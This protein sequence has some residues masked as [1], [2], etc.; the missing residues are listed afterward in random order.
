MTPALEPT[1]SLQESTRV[2]TLWRFRS[3]QELGY[4]Y[5]ALSQHTTRAFKY[6]MVDPF[7][8]YTTEMLDLLKTTLCFWASKTNLLGENL[9]KLHK[10]SRILVANMIDLFLTKR[11]L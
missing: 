5:Y 4:V 2:A 8:F 11:K 6:C 10:A 1:S 7:I 9:N 3:F